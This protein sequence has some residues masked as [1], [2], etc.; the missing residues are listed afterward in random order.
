MS[1]SEIERKEEEER[2]NGAQAGG[3]KMSRAPRPSYTDQ[4]IEHL[5]Q[6]LDDEI[7][8]QPVIEQIKIFSRKYA[9]EMKKKQEE[10]ND[11]PIKC[12]LF[13]KYKGKKISDVAKFD[14]KYLMWLRRQSFIRPNLKKALDK[15]LKKKPS[16]N[17]D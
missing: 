3:Q 11:K 17:T 5:C 7:D 6:A 16:R 2:P 8:L 12:L 14:V 4:M 13:G 15:V 10:D 1:D 9:S